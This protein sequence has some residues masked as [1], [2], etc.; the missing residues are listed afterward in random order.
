M[1]GVGTYPR[2][3]VTAD[4]NGDGAF[5]LVTANVYSDNV[6][7]LLNSVSLP[8]IAGVVPYGTGTWGCMGQLS[9]YANS[10]PAVGSSS[11]AVVGSNAPRN[12]LGLTLASNV[13]D[14]TG[15]D[16]FYANLLTHFAFEGAT[17]VIALDV[18]SGPSGEQFAPAPI[19]NF[20]ALV[21]K[22]YFLQTFWVE[23]PDQRCTHG[24]AGLESSR[25]LAVTIQP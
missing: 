22:A 13:Q 19:P 17:E 4:L 9:L 24:L 3:V 5:D 10:L 7:V 23:P 14:L 16:P 25:G 21:G 12:A 15:S 1:F 2:S 8:M 11:F 6:S 20:P 18:Y